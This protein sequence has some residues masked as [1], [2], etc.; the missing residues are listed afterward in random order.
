[1]IQSHVE[2]LANP[3]HDSIHLPRESAFLSNV[4]TAGNT[5]HTVHEL[6]WDNKLSIRVTAVAAPIINFLVTVTARGGIFR[7]LILRRD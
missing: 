1:M 5:H 4:N 6:F 3:N 7:E 2:S